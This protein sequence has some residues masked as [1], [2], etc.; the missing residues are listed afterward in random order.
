MG[1]GLIGAETSNLAAKLGLATS[2]VEVDKIGIDQ[3]KTRPTD[4]NKLS[5]VVD[6]DVAKKLC[7]I[8]QLETLMLLMVINQL[9]I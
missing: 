8:K 6:N 4:L 9:E 5:N 7:L 1:Q 3:E 2:Q